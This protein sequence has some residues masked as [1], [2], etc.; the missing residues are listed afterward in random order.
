M[1]R[2]EDLITSCKRQDPQSLMELYNICSHE[3]YNVSY[4]IVLNEFDAE[5]IMQDS[6]LKA[7]DN[8]NRFSGTEKDFMAFVKRIAVNKSIDFYRKHSRLP[9]F[10]DINDHN[11]DF[12]TENNEEDTEEIFPVEKIREE[13]E[14]LPRGYKTIICLHLIDNIDFADIADIMNIKASTVRSQYARAKEKLKKLLKESY[15]HGK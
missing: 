12:S 3:V 7:F 11:R 8:I 2:F 4:H 9:V 13:I 5:E 15:N 6:I 10:S 1:S 14:N